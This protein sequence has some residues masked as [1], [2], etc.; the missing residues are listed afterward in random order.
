[1]GRWFANVGRDE[2]GDCGDGVFFFL[3]LGDDNIGVGGVS[4]S[5]ASELE[6][7]VWLLFFIRGSV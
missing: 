5:F 7:G 6:F 4:T 1:M 3:G 2:L